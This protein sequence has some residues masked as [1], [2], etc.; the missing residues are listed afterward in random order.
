MIHLNMQSELIL[1]RY[2]IKEK[3]AE[4]EQQM[5]NGA[6]FD[7]LKIIQMEIKKLETDRRYFL[8]EIEK[9]YEL[10]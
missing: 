10:V 8:E 6:M 1:L 4:Y 5:I 3:K 2:E 7:Q 9:L